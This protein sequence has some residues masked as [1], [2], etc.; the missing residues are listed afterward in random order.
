VADHETPSNPL[1]ALVSAVFLISFPF[2]LLSF[3]LPIL[4]KGMGASAL[5][6]AGLY[7]AFS[8][9][10]VLLRPGV[11]WAL[12]RYGRR[13]FLLVGLVGY[14]SA[15]LIFL[16]ADNVTTLYAARLAQSIGSAL[17]WLSAYAI[18]AD[19]S[20]EDTRGRNFG[21]VEQSQARAMLAGVFVFFGVH[22]ALLQVNL[23]AP[24]DMDLPWKVSF[25]IFA[26][27][28]LYALWRVRHVPE[29]GQRNTEVPLWASL[30][31]SWRRVSRPLLVLLGI[32][33]LTAAAFQATSPLVLIF[34]QDRF[35]ASLFELAWA[36]LPMALIWSF[37][38]SRMGVISD[39]W[40][41]KLPMAAG[42]LVSGGVALFLP[43]APSLVP[44]A[45]LWA[46]EALAF[47]AS[48]P[49]EE[50]LVAD[51]SGSDQR[52]ESFGL[53]TFASGLGAVI[54]PIFGG[55]L[56]DSAGHAVPFYFTAALVFLGAILILLLVRDPRCASRSSF[57]GL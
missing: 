33:F 41:R 46:V 10:T 53:Y 6:I 15:N 24:E 8:L 20:L 19:L 5:A 22:S 13:P 28:G 38:P 39:R 7:S 48:V 42:L 36:Y 27:L 1:H 45:I 9:M 25:G 52:G 16:W 54:G 55:W 35:G 12:D 43:H 23:A 37:L 4:G 57:S 11:G 14:L 40:G 50:A 29:T 44:L 2:G 47:T 18:V 3:A 21:R 32:V 51:L 49:A 26:G 30:R 17:T 56:Y 31:S 34:L